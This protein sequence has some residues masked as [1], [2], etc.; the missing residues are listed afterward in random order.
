MAG[1]Q[2]EKYYFASTF[3]ISL[4]YCKIRVSLGITPKLVFEGFVCS[5]LLVTHTLLVVKVLIAL[6]QAT[7]PPAQQLLS[8]MLDQH[9]MARV[10]RM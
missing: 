7:H 10:G 1:V 8:G 4:F 2:V 5:L 3:T 6:A 9:R